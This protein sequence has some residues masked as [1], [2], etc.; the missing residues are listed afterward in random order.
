MNIGKCSQYTINREKKV[1][2]LYVKYDAIFI[3]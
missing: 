1:L 3:L 2:K